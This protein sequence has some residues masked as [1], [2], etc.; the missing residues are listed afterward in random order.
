[1]KKAIYTLSL[2][3]F[4]YCNSIAAQVHYTASGKG[5]SCIYISAREYKQ[6]KPSFNC[7]SLCVNIRLNHFFSGNYIIVQCKGKKYR[8][9]KDSIWGYTNGKSE[10]FRFYKSHDEE[11]KIIDTGKIVLYSY[12]VIIWSGN[13]RFI[14][15]EQRYFFSKTIDSP[16]LP[17]TTLELKRAFPENLK[18]HD[19]LDLQFGNTQAISEVGIVK[20][21]EFLNQST[22]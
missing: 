9:N 21:K 10:H 1:M 17:F 15:S 7:D 3:Y 4:V 12:P 6:S 13:G 14:R 11:Y 5:C 8:L 19:M 22:Q 18:F 2:L 16:I 20:I